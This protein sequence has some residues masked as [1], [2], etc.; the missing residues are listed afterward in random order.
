PVIGVPVALQHLDGMDSL[1]SIVQMPGGVPVAA[2]GV[3]NAKN[4]A[5]LAARIIA[6]GGSADDLRIRAALDDLRVAAAHKA[7]A[8]GDALRKRRSQPAGF[9]I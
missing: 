4:G 2:V 3:G 7:M 9:G 5:L 8:S 6:S 1:L